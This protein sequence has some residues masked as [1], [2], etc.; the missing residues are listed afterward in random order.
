MDTDHHLGEA[1]L[2]QRGPTAPHPRHGRG[3]VRHHR[4]TR[5]GQVVN[6]RPSAFRLRGRRG[7]RPKRPRANA[8]A[9][10]RRTRRLLEALSHDRRTTHHRYRARGHRSSQRRQHVSR[11]FGRRRSGRRRSPS[12]HRR[13]PQHQRTQA[14]GSGVASRRRRGPHRLA[15]AVAGG[16]AGQRRRT[17]GQHRP[18][19][20]QPARHGSLPV[21]GVLAATPADDPQRRPLEIVEQEVERM[22]GLVANLLQF[23][24][25]GPAGVHGGRRRRDRRTWNSSTTSSASGIELHREFA[26][27][28]RRSTPTGSSCGRCS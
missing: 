2:R 23:S 18:R 14:I 27:S 4:R 6:P 5:H 24:R 11:R 26:P 9:V 1:L 22:A 16:Q 8:V 21:E 13:R 28:V 19:V 7:R 10:P 25:R 15:A 20:E 12:L 17:G 3:C